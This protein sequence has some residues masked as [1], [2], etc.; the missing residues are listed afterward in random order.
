MLIIKANQTNTLVVTVSQN[1]ELVNPE[2]LFSFTHIFTKEKVRFIP[3]DIS[4]HKSRYDE[5]QFV[6]GNN[7]GEISFPYEGQYLYSIWAQPAGSGNLNPALASEQVENGLA[8][9]YVAS[10]MTDESNFDFFISPDEENANYIFAPDE[11]NPEPTS[12]PTQSVTPT[13]TQTPTSSETPTPTPTPSVTVTASPSQTPTL[14][15]TNTETPTQTPTN[16]PT[17]TNTITPSLTPTNTQTPTNTP[18]KTPTPTV[19]PSST[20]LVF[21]SDAAAYLNAVVASGG[22]LSYSISAATNTLFTELKSNGLFS[23]MTLMYPL[24][25]GTSG[26]TSINAATPGTYNITWFGGMSFDSSGA[27]GNGSTGY[28]NTNWT[29]TNTLYSSGTFSV[30]TQ[31]NAAGFTCPIGAGPSNNARWMLFGDNGSYYHMDWG[32]DASNTGRINNVGQPAGIKR[33]LYVVSSTGNTQNRSI[34]NGGNA[35]TNAG[36][37]TKANTP[38]TNMYLFRRQDGLYFSGGIGF[39]SVGELLTS[40]QMTTLSTIINTWAT[41][42]GRNTY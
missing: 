38:N 36:S 17:P 33:G 11:L 40:T 41:S 23:G 14:T 24:L 15:P 34:V 28:G 20:P 26:S 19:T 5:F 37:I 1:T 22:T 16:T 39:A 27:T 9:V 35:Q 10:A 13:N 12:T 4:T 8:Q 29:P 32:G 18:T 2:Y 21:D 42:I 31:T 3:T 30:Y 6:E 7:P 25:G